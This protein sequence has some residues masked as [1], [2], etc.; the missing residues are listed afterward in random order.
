MLGPI[1]FLC[2]INDLP[3]SISS[4]VRLFADD[5]IMYK[6]MKS[7]IDCQSLQYDLTKLESWEK[8]WGMCFH[9]DKCNI[10][11]MTRKNS[12][13]FT[14]THCHPRVTVAQTNYLGVT[15]SGNLTWNNHINS[16][17]NNG[18]RTLGFIRGNIRTSSLKAKSLAYTSLVRPQLEYCSTVW[19]PHQLTLKCQLEVTQR[20]AARYACQNFH[21]TASVTEMI[22]N[23][24]KQKK[25]PKTNYA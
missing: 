11:R 23:P 15:V 20:R 8:T 25:I 22:T 24:G 10:I 17:A 14:T 3:S 6:Q 5:S 13:S 9:Q 12:L 16:I 19:D 18:N 7:P 2:Y 21:Q 4:N 1:L